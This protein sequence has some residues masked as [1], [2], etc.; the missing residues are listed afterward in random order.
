MRNLCDVGVRPICLEFRVALPDAREDALARGDGIFGSR[1]RACISRKET[2]SRGS[3]PWMKM[4]RGRQGGIAC[5]AMM[6]HSRAS[7]PSHVGPA[8]SEQVPWALGLTDGDEKE[9]EPLLL[10]RRGC[11]NRKRC[12]WESKADAVA[13]PAPAMNPGLGLPQSHSVPSAASVVPFR[14]FAIV[15][16]V[17]MLRHRLHSPQTPFW[18]S[19]RAARATK[20]ATRWWASGFRAKPRRT[21]AAPRPQ[22][23]PEPAAPYPR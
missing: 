13:S 1:S 4:R 8:F 20:N 11:D 14:T 19:S 12:L 3:Q 15:T 23:C 6:G 7:S 21:S 10:H 16:R 17:A 5:Q 22:S 2:M 18:R 9:R